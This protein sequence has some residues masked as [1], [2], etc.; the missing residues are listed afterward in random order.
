MAD[1]TPLEAILNS[2][3]TQ[4]RALNGRATDEAIIFFVGK[5]N[6]FFSQFQ[7][8]KPTNTELKQF[9]KIMSKLISEINSVEVAY[10]Q[11]KYEFDDEMKHV[12]LHGYEITLNKLTTRMQYWAAAEGYADAIRNPAAHR[13]AVLKLDQ[14][15]GLASTVKTGPSIFQEPPKK[16]GF[17]PAADSTESNFSM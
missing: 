17:E 14:W 1:F 4:L 8:K 11:K 12:D 16:R 5:L 9:L 6:E 10:Y 13:E 7:N 15:I 2:D 3:L